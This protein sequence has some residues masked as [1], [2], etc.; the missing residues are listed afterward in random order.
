MGDGFAI[1]PLIYW[2]S[3]RKHVERGILEHETPELQDSAS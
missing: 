2:R 1:T 3:P